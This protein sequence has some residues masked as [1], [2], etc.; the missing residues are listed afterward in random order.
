MKKANSQSGKRCGGR[1]M[2]EDCLNDA[3]HREGCKR[4]LKRRGGRCL[5]EDRGFGPRFQALSD[6]QKRQLLQSELDKLNQAQ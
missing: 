5:Q 4:G 6:E 1:H 2:A 3:G